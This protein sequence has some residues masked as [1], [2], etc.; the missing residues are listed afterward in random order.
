MVVTVMDNA[1]G[2][3]VPK[4]T[5]PNSR[6]LVMSLNTET[7]TAEVLKRFDHPKG[8][9]APARGNFQTLANGNGFLSWTSM[10]LQSEHS[11]DGK[12][13]MEAEIPSG[14]KTYRG[15]K[16]PWVGKPNYPPDVYSKVV[17]VDG[18][19]ITTVHVSWNGATEVVAW[20]LYKSNADGSSTEQVASTKRSGFET[21][22][23]Y[24]GYA[25]YVIVKAI[26]KD[27]KEIGKSR[28]MQ[29][30]GLADKLH[31]AAIKEAQ[32]LQ[33]HSKVPVPSGGNDHAEAHDEAHEDAHEDEH[34]DH[35]E[36][37]EE[38]E[39]SGLAH[40]LEDVASVFNRPIVAFFGGIVFCVAAALSAWAFWA[41]RRKG[42][43]SWQSKEQKYSELSD[44]DGELER[45]EFFDKDNQVIE[46]A[47]RSDDDGKRSP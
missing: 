29:T 36:E 39:H 25:S 45:E 21:A 6:G 12:V 4:K 1:S 17:P 33:E 11:P 30:R 35:E 34:D 7:M 31:T 40:S 16:F 46:E 14:L 44:S 8:E 41:A 3:G 5:N 22:L 32:W 24:K 38:E 2:P 15:Y 43:L 27:G 19:L 9:Y 47:E 20:K 26:D 42:K 23:T 37:E 10:A 13:I 18:S 28:M